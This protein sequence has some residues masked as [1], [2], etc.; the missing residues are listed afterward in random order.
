MIKGRYM[1]IRTSPNQDIFHSA[2]N[3]YYEANLYD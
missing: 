1:D 2:R 3:S